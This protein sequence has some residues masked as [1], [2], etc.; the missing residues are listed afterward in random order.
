MGV[1]RVG[2][3]R[4]LRTGI[5]WD[6]GVVGRG[7]PEYVCGLEERAE[8]LL[9][10]PALRWIQFLPNP[11]SYTDLVSAYPNVGDRYLHTAPPALFHINQ[12]QIRDVVKMRKIHW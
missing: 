5:V 11:V 8:T 3:C 2:H 10:G 7:L 9:R 6:N 4:L 1:V 12:L